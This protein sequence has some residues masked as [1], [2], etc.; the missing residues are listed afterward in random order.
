MVFVCVCVCVCQKDL[1]QMSHPHRQFIR[2]ARRDDVHNA[3]GETGDWPLYPP[4]LRR[5][6]NDRMYCRVCARHVPL[7]S[8]P[9]CTDCDKYA[10][11]DREIRL[12]VDAA[13]RVVLAEHLVATTPI[14]ADSAGIVASYLD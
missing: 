6:Q 14:C 4:M 2:L 13:R 10:H 12:G 1:K 5:Q 9:A 7:R 11:I 3:T 8:T